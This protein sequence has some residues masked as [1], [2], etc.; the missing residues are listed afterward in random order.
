MGIKQTMQI[1]SY[2]DIKFSDYK[3]IPAVSNSYLGRLD[4][5][6]ASAKIEIEETP[7]MA[8]GKAA[9][10]YILD[11]TT[12]DRDFAVAPACDRRTK[13]G[14]E[15]YAS[16][17]VDN[18]NKI[19]ITEE[20]FQQVKCIGAAVFEHPTAKVL[21]KD[22]ASEQTIIWNDHET[23]L[24]C[25]S[26]IDRVPHD[27]DRVLVDLKTTRDASER[28]FIRSCVSYGYIRQAAMYQ[29][30]YYFAADAEI[31]KFVFIAV[32]PEPPYR[33]EVYDVDSDFLGWGYEEFHRLLRIEKECRIKGVYPHYQNA[34]AQVLV[35]PGYLNTY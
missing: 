27:I 30:G 22:G 32:E 17:Q 28:A 1:G 9:H 23:G 3:K 20:E 26:R 15:A 7:A 25:K 6:P 18:L 31:D 4:H 33:V 13:A 10:A 12:F 11:C 24:T 16:F 21:L 19:I 29:E 8:L 14:K 35:K 34:G 5:C 2:S